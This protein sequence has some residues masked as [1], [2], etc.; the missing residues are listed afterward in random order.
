MRWFTH[1]SSS[2]NNKEQQQT[3]WKSSIAH[4]L[5]SVVCLR[6]VHPTNEREVAIE[7]VLYTKS[8]SRRSCKNLAKMTVSPTTMNNKQNDVLAAGAVPALDITPI[9]SNRNNAVP[10]I[11]TSMMNMNS[12]SPTTNAMML[13]CS[14][15][16]TSTETLQSRLLLGGASSRSPSTKSATTGGGGREEIA[17]GP[18]CQYQ[19]GFVDHLTPKALITSVRC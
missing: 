8:V 16:S 19:K 18:L 1:S 10:T 3:T 14:S 17:D 2:I 13:A 7:K 9:V 15:S 4:P 5:D 6:S 11:K 12:M